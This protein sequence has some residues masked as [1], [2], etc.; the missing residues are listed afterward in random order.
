LTLIVAADSKGIYGRCDAK[1]HDATEPECHCI[2]G[3]RFYGKGSGT[4]D[5]SSPVIIW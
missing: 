2:C 3:G 1:C 5:G 4:P